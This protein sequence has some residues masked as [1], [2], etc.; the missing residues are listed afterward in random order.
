MNLPNNGRKVKDFW[1]ITSTSESRISPKE[2]EQLIFHTEFHGQ[3]DRDWILLVK[4]GVEI[5]RFNTSFIA[6]INFEV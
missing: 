3:Y 4:N 6:E 5:S 1:F 2:G